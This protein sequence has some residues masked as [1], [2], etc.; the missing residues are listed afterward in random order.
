MIHFYWK[1]GDWFPKWKGGG[2]FICASTVFPFGEPSHPN[3]LSQGLF[4]HP[5]GGYVRDLWE[6]VFSSYEGSVGKL[7]AAGHLL[8]DGSR[9]Q[10]EVPG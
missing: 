3:L 7:L 10:E 2:R 6:D 4:D 5:K 8:R 9:L 1:V